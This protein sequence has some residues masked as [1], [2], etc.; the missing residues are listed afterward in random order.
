MSMST[1]HKRSSLSTRSWSSRRKETPA[2]EELM[3]KFACGEMTAPAGFGELPKTQLVNIMK[4]F[5]E[6][7]PKGLATM[8]KNKLVELVMEHYDPS[9]S[10]TN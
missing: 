6:S 4:Y 1:W 5:Y 9:H 7:R 3:T 8:S 10:E 2:L